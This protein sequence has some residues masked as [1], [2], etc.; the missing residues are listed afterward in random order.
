[1]WA[2]RWRRA[3]AARY[4]RPQRREAVPAQD[5]AEK[6]GSRVRGGGAGAGEPEIDFFQKSGPDLRHHF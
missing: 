1:M 6:A 4:V 3:F 5:L 2:L